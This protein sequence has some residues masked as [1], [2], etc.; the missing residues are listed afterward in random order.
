MNFACYRALSIASA[1]AL[2]WTV[3]AESKGISSKPAIMIW[4][5]ERPENL[6]SIDPR[7]VGVSYF[8]LNIKVTRK[9][10]FMAPRLQSIVVPKSAYI[11]GV[12]HIE[13]EPDS[14]S[15]LSAARINQI[16]QAIQTMANGLKLQSVQIDFD[17]KS[18]ERQSYALLLRDLRKRLPPDVHLSMTALSS[19]CLYDYWLEDLAVDEIV[20]M[21]FS[22]GADEQKIL[23]LLKNGHD[24]ASN[25]CKQALGVS[26]DGPVMALAER[27]S[28]VAG[29]FK[30]RRV[31]VFSSQR[32]TPKSV[33]SGIER[34]EKIRA[35]HS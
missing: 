27:S 12:V 28:A 11:E 23:L 9:E 30:N 32:W 35:G 10:T 26:S 14:M 6:D 31:Y 24:F 34:V 8:A 29:L 15:A 5:W 19:W 13:T 33:H 20:P 3:C 1:L 4:A 2:G 16:D 25:R 18:S 7:R 17:A 21:L 22:L